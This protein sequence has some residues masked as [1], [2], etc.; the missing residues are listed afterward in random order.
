MAELI[1]GLGANLGDARANLE[2]CIRLLGKQLGPVVARSRMYRSAAWGKRDQPDFINMAVRLR[3]IHRPEACL[4]RIRGI[5][6]EFGPS[7]QKRWGARYMDIDI[8]F[9]DREVYRSEH[10][11]IPHPNLSRRNFVL[12]PLKDLIPAYRHPESRKSIYRLE[13]ECP[14]KGWTEIL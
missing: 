5:Q 6:S 4:S 9:Y 11:I 10:L 2:S 8:L 14:D 1:L 7:K 12:R 3:S 13:R